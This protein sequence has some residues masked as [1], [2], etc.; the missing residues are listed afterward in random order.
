MKFLITGQQFAPQIAGQPQQHEGCGSGNGAFQLRRTDVRTEVEKLQPIYSGNG[1]CQRY[2]GK[3]RHPT[4]Q[5]KRVGEVARR[6][7]LIAQGVR[8][9]NM[10]GQGVG[11]AKVKQVDPH[12]GRGDGGPHAIAF[13][14]Q[15]AYRERQGD[16][17]ER[18]A[19]AA[20]QPC[21]TTR[22]CR[23]GRSVMLTNWSSR[24]APRAA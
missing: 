23:C 14:P 18:A 9:R 13:R 5:D 21:L 17:G 3:C 2:P 4:C 7:R 12:R 22:P 8:P 11:N 20:S 16:Q 6:R 1:K 19:S 24:Y 15:I 10:V